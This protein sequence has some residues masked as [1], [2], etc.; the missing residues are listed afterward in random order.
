M[1]RQNNQAR[2]ASDRLTLAHRSPNLRDARKES[3]NAARGLASIQQL[4]S[5]PRLNVKRLRGIRQ[6]PNRQFKQFPLGS[7]HWTVIKVSRYRRRIERGRHNNDAYL[8]PHALETLQKRQRKIAVKV[9][10]VEF[11]ED[12]R[13]D[14]FESRICQQTA[15]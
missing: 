9:T 11:V 1:Q 8:R 7:K 12:D 10:F 3:E 4:H 13:V 14:A 2:L 5:P 6:M 15:G